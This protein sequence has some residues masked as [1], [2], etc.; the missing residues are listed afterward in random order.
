MRRH[1]QASAR[2]GDAPIRGMLVGRVRL[3][4]ARSTVLGLMV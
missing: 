1:I 3:A 4:P 2:N